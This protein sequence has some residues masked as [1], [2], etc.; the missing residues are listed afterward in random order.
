MS[1]G[2]EDKSGRL[3]AAFNQVDQASKTKKKKRSSISPVTLRLTPE[4][5]ETLE[6]LAADPG[7][8]I[9]FTHDVSTEPSAFGMTPNQLTTLLLRARQ[10]GIEVCPPAEAARKAGVAPE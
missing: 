7:W 1:A 8:M 3:A 9:M 6:D 10:L 2:F 4:E 5:R